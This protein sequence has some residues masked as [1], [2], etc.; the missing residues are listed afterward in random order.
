MIS[1]CIPESIIPIDVGVFLEICRKN[2]NNRM[3]RTK[4]GE[5]LLM[6]HLRVLK[7][8]NGI[9]SSIIGIFNI[10]NKIQKRGKIFRS[11]I[12]TIFWFFSL[13]LQVVQPQNLKLRKNVV[14]MHMN[15]LP[16]IRVWVYVR[17]IPSFQSIPHH[18]LSNWITVF[19]IPFPGISVVRKNRN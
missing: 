2:P 10:W 9:L 5:I 18:I 6:G 14:E 7:R 8:V 12:N 19:S 15:L 17:P 16:S 1:L 4:K 3:E 13:F 11:T